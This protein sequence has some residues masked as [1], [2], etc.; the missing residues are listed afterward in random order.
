MRLHSLLS[1]YILLPLGK[2]YSRRNYFKALKYQHFLEETQY[3]ERSAIEAW[4]TEHF[5]KLIAHC[6]ENVPYYRMYM[7]KYDLHPRD[8]QSLEDVKK[9]PVMTKEI[10]NEN[11]ELLKATNYKQRDIRYDTT[12]GTTGVPA[13]I[14]IDQRNEYRVDAMWRRCWGYAG[15]VPGM[16][17]MLFWCNQSELI[18]NKSLHERVKGIM[19]NSITLDFMDLYDSRLEQYAKYINK[20]QPEVIRGYSNAVYLFVQYCNKNKIKFVKSPKGIIITSDKIHSNQKREISE[21][22]ECEIFEEYGCHEF[23]VIAHECEAHKGLH[24]AEEHFI[25]EVFNPI[26]QNFSFQGEGDIIIS[27]LFNYALPLLR[28][29]LGDRVFL[30]KESCACGRNLKLISDLYGRTVDF[31]LTKSDRVFYGSFFTALF[32]NISGITKYQVHQYKKGEIIIYL[33]KN[34]KF[35]EKEIENV[36]VQLKNIFKDDMSFEYKYVDEIDIPLSGKRTSFISNISYSYLKDIY[37]KCQ[38]TV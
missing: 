24:L 3:W 6:Y 36:S 18:K 38:Y 14:G 2:T 29:N 33:I 11:F 21:F 27:S 23:S 35:D 8:F 31:A 30:S 28:Y 19:N 17:I 12:G 34:D 4:R 7:D 10:L 15:Y 5:L 13:T 26:S 20:V 16:K 9:L 22:F 25:F 37:V 32:L 1:R